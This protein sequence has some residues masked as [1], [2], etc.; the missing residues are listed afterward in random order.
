MTRR[1]LVKDVASS[2]A[3][4]IFSFSFPSE[5]VVVVVVSKDRDEMGKG[6]L[7]NQYRAGRQVMDG[8]GRGGWNGMV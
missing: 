4:Q 1:W 2:H 5:V 7:Q 8:T 6:D 3:W